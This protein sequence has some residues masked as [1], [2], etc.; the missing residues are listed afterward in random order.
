MG[1]R[2]SPRS[3]ASR[4]GCDCRGRSS[5]PSCHLSPP[6]RCKCV[7]RKWGWQRVWVC[8]RQFKLDA[9]GCLYLQDGLLGVRLD[10]LPP[11]KERL[12]IDGAL[13][14]LAARQRQAELHHDFPKLSPVDRT[15]LVKVVFLKLPAA[16]VQI[17]PS[18]VLLERD[19][20]VAVSVEIRMRLIREEGVGTGLVEF[21]IAEANAKAV[22]ELGNLV[23][24][25][26][27]RVILII[28]PED[29]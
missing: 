16:V 10:A 18:H 28:E 4:R 29:A 25:D 9:E 11:S 13:V 6:E 8:G 21:V 3:R 7:G 15:T 12:E 2:S 5:P 27:A 14:S 22:H 26:R 23:Q 19:R 17:E 1:A 20:T 24:I